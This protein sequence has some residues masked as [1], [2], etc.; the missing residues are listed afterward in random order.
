MNCDIKLCKA[1][2]CGVV[3]I[4][5]ETV[6]KHKNK[7]HLDAKE[8]PSFPGTMIFS[9][10]MICGFLNIENKC[11]IYEDRPEVC[12]RYG[13]GK[14]SHPMLRCKYLGQIMSEEQDS[15]FDKMMDNMKGGS[16]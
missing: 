14:E 4:P 15:F 9:R 7:L 1:T 2:C 16:L 11:S 13:S 8:I 5:E 6:K 10:D 3:P 12:R